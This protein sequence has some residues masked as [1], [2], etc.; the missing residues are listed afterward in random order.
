[1]CASMDVCEG[2]NFPFDVKLSL[3]Y[4]YVV[5]VQYF[6]AFSPLILNITMAWLEMG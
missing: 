5:F 2:I 3:R 4:W 6:S 1:M